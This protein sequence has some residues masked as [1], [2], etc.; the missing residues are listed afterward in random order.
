MRSGVILF[1]NAV[2]MVVIGTTISFLITKAFSVER[3]PFSRLWN[4]F[5]L[6]AGA[7]SLIAWVPGAFI[8]T[9]PWKWWLIGIGMVKGLKM[10]K[11]GAVITIL[12]T[13]G[14]TVTLVLAVLSISNRMVATGLQ[15]N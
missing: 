15:A 1:T 8:L 5:A 2:G 12:F 7:V 9:E 6:C 14:I 4:L 13:F 3:Y 11:L 10:T